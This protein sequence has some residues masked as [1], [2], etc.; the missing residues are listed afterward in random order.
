MSDDGGRVVTLPE[1]VRSHYPFASQWFDNAGL[2]QHYVDE[3]KGEP[4]LM[5]HGNPTWS[6]FFRRL[7]AD[8]RQGYRVIAPDHIGCG[9]SARPDDAAYEFSLRRRIDDVERL[10]DQLALKSNITLV[11]HDWGG[12]IGMG[13]AARRPES[14]KRIVLMNTAA[15]RLP[16]GK[17]LPLA[18]KLC[19]RGPQGAFLVRGLNAFCRGAQLTCVRPGRLSKDERLGY[20][21]PYDS[22]HNR[23]AV[24]RFVQDIPLVPTDPSFTD[25]IATERLLPVFRSTPM[26]IF[27]GAKDFVFDDD[28]LAVWRER[29][30]QAEVHRYPDA[31]HYVL[32][33]AWEDIVPRV[34]S[35][36]EAN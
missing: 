9:L 3:G 2:R 29:F 28:F 6:F 14:I 10:V 22:W 23:L 19:R 12:M 25:V 27:W 5:L 26:Q 30:P 36:L 15:F 32:E 16:Q 33:D 17:R 11:L 34:R 35:F 8:L 31:G 18:L 4:V 20:L 1:A 7:I 13:F 21:A 24:H